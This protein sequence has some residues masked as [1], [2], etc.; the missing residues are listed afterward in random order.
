MGLDGDKEDKEDAKTSSTPGN[1]TAPSAYPVNATS[2]KTPQWSSDNVREFFYIYEAQFHLN[3]ITSEVTKFW[4]VISGL[5]PDVI[6]KAPKN[7][8][9]NPSYNTLKKALVGTFDIPK[10]EIFNRLA[11]ST[12]LIGKP[13]DKLRS[14]VDYG[15]RAGVSDDYVRH[16]F[17]RELPMTIRPVIAARETT[18]LSDLGLLADDLMSYTKT[19][20]LFVGQASNYT[21]GASEYPK[22]NNN[23]SKIAPFHPDQRPKVCRFHIFYGSKATKCKNFCQWPDKSSVKILP[24]SRSGSPAPSSRSSSRYSSPHKEN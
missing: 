11:Q 22:R 20:E 12:P 10:P 14:L 19:N 2:I 15:E 6:K 17:I 13:S 24:S 4:H 21:P 9:D 18:P 7:V 1:Q 8:M 5:P 23:F 3:N 16:R